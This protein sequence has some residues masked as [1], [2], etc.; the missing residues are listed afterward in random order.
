MPNGIDPA[1]SSDGFQRIPAGWR[2]SPV[3]SAARQNV[4]DVRSAEPAA[5]QNRN[6]RNSILS[7]SVWRLSL[8]FLF[9][10]RLLRRTF[11]TVFRK[12]SCSLRLRWCHLFAGRQLP[13]WLRLAAPHM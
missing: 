1:R 10:D 13:V 5:G 4:F 9:K 3:V 8:V 6:A 11:G 12:G 7:T 2:V